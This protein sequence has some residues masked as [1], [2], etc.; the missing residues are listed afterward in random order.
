VIER[1]HC[2]L[3]TFRRHS[4]TA[5]RIRCLDQLAAWLGQGPVIIGSQLQERWYG[6]CITLLPFSQGAAAWVETKSSAK[7]MGEGFR[8]L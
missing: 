6:R 3:I 5:F 4:R 1:V 2:A 7:I 8:V